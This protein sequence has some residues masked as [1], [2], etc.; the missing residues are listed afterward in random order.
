[1]N[2]LKISSLRIR[3]FRK[4]LER[5]LLL[6]VAALVSVNG[7]S[8]TA[9]DQDG[10]DLDLERHLQQ[11][12]SSDEMDQLSAAAELAALG[13]RA[14]AARPRLERLLDNSNR[15]LQ[16]ECLT[17]LGS[18][19]P[20]ARE[21]APAVGR[22]VNSDAAFLQIAALDSLRQIGSV[23]PALVA[24]IRAL[25]DAADVAIS[26]AAARCLISAVDA[27][28]ESAEPLLV[29]LVHNFSAAR[30]DVRGEAALGLMEA[31]PKVIPLVLPLL[32]SPRWPV[33]ADTCRILAHFDADSRSAAGAIRLLLSDR[34]ELVVRAAAEA[35]GEIDGEAVVALPM[36]A[37]LLRRESDGLRLTAIRAIGRFGSQASAHVPELLPFLRS[38]SP[39]ER[40]AAA[41]ALGR[42]GDGNPDSISALLPLLNDA[43]LVTAH[44]AA[45]A[46]AAQGSAAVPYLV[47]RLKNDGQRITALEVLIEMGPAAEQALPELLQGISGGFVGTIPRRL[48]LRAIG[49]MGSAA[50]AAAPKIQELL[51]SPLQA[52]LHPAAAWVLGRIGSKAAIPTLQ[53]AAESEDQRTRIAAACALVM[54]R[55]E[56]DLLKTKAVPLLTE[57]LDNNLSLVRR[58]SLMA[59]AEIGPQA[60]TAVPAVIRLATIDADPDV[61]AAALNTLAEIG[62]WTSEQTPIASRDVTALMLTSMEDPSFKVREAA[63]LL[64]GRMQTAGA[65]A[66]QRLRDG[67]H[68]GDIRHRVLCA[69]ALLKTV[70]DTG[71]LKL[72]LPLM[73][74]AAAHPDPWIRKEA[75]SALSGAAG[76]N[77]EARQLLLRL[78]EDIHPSVRHA[79]GA[80]D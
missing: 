59:L 27:P 37:E 13:P 1:M 32:N 20:L 72:A 11:L 39:L 47:P 8:I 66:E 63:C 15:I 35:I 70:P 3:S 19:G 45:I 41:E 44:H 67:L 58:E 14:V 21:S 80:G 43:H 53:Q 78:R 62:P 7:G 55:A 23:P 50:T 33:R 60:L 10:F 79:A 9:R 30:P 76:D 16:L 18:L 4:G 28:D 29:T 48:A 65:A 56:T 26:T 74:K 68:S 17:A 64:A 73:K 40:S 34:V 12:E 61:R 77:N 31:G 6:G 38:T 36:L 51:E 71:S 69:W 42:I 24:R 22:F 52:E 2:S 5:L 54:L 57:A 49:E 25:A 46:I 75:A